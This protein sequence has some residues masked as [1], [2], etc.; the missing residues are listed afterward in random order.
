MATIGEA[1]DPLSF[2]LTIPDESTPAA[3][4]SSL[5]LP[6]ANSVLA[7][8][9]RLKQQ[10]QS[11]QHFTD[12]FTPVGTDWNVDSQVLHVYGEIHGY[13][14][15][16]L[17][18]KVDITVPSTG[19]IDNR[20]VGNMAAGFN[21]NSQAVLSAGSAGRLLSAYTLNDGTVKLSAINSG[22]DIHAG[23]HLTMG[24]YVPLDNP[25][26]SGI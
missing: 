20:I 9:I 26:R 12:K 14:F 15:L 1:N 16:S 23:D 25:V 5:F 2:V 17:I 21:A 18:A 7:A 8:L 19:N 22:L 4:F 13:L 24:G 6:N 3:P 10:V 11:T